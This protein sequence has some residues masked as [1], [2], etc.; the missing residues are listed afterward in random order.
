MRFTNAMMMEHETLGPG[1]IGQESS[2]VQSLRVPP[3]GGG[4]IELDRILGLKAFEAYE[5]TPDGIPTVHHKDG[6]TVRTVVWDDDKDTVTTTSSVTSNTRRGE[7]ADVACLTMSDSPFGA[8]S[9]AKGRVRNSAA[10]S[11]IG[12]KHLYTAR[13]WSSVDEVYHVRAR[14]YSPFEGRFICRDPIGYAGAASQ[15][16]YCMGDPIN[17]VDPSGLAVFEIGGTNSIDDPAGLRHTGGRLFEAIGFPGEAYVFGNGP[18]SSSLD[19]SHPQLL[20]DAN[21]IANEVCRSIIRLAKASSDERIMPV[22]HSRGGAIANVVAREVD[23]VDILILLDPVG[24]IRD[25]RFPFRDTVFQSSS[26]RT[27][28]V[29]PTA[30]DGNCTDHFR[31]FTQPNYLSRLPFWRIQQNPNAT[32]RANRMTHGG[33]GGNPVVPVRTFFTP[34]GDST[35]ITRQ[36]S[37]QDFPRLIRDLAGDCEP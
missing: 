1:V 19:S 22:G 14:R 12:I 17:H 31:S 15:Y 13:P 37:E 21:R 36:D 30:G 6:A 16:I 3:G 8:S 20:A 25:P 2:G 18:T 9:F 4:I 34:Y 10:M 7:F 35:D 26:Q 27:I 23:G 28:D 32:N 29:R 24:E 5:Y 33:L 11:R